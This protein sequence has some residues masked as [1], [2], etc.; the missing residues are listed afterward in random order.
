LVNPLLGSAI[1]FGEQIVGEFRSQGANIGG[2][3]DEIARFDGLV[4]SGIAADDAW[5]ARHGLSPWSAQQQPPAPQPAPTPQPQPQP[6]QPPAEP[7]PGVGSG[8][9]TGGFPVGDGQG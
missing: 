5:R 9:D 3:A 7:T 6:P 8:A 4:G 2:F 1:M